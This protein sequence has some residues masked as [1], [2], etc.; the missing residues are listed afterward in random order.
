MQVLIM[1]NFNSFNPELQLK[2]T[3]ST[4]RDKLID[5]STELKGFKFLKALVL[6]FEKIKGDGKTKY[7]TFYLN[8]KT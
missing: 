6:E 7:S 2:D 8:L 3:E 4:F 5:L 1:L